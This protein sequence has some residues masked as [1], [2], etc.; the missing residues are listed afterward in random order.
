MKSLR[1][2]VVALAALLLP[3]AAQAREVTDLAGR[4]VH[5]PDHPTRILL[6]EGRF[7]FAMAL[8]DRANPV[9]RV[10]GWQGEL[11]AQD[12]QAWKQLLDR[13][14]QAA[15]IPFIGKNSEA[16]VSPERIVSLH[17]DLAIFGL[18][19][20]GPGPANPMIAALQH[21]G[22]PILFID[23]RAKPLQ[24][25]IPS[26]RVL[27][28]ALGREHEAERYIDFAQQ[29]RAAV[30]AVVDGVPAEQRPRVFVEL[31][32]GVWPACCHTTGAGGLGDMESA[33]GGRNIASERVPG[34]IGDV[35]LEYLIQQQPDVYI[36]TGSRNEP[37][38]PSIVAGPGVAPGVVN[39]SLQAVLSR[40][41]IKDLNAVREQRA[42]GLWHAFYNSPYNI[43]A[44]EA[45]AKWFYPAS[46][47]NPQ[48]SMDRLYRDFV[49]LDGQGSYWTR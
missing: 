6:G 7:V 23:F 22:I 28:Q 46:D 17:P 38:R 26:L 49:S 15:A 42:H 39:G 48:A 37:G 8:L 29:R 35:S 25:T 9:Q 5:V 16:S 4:Q 41:G 33:A 31:L 36:A 18:S 40:D 24:N 2:A 34:A 3:A 14:P 10:V 11:K 44:I 21:A 20:H 32:A 30:Q 12:P 43:I 45:L 1:I 47:L 19:G 13:Y 27:G